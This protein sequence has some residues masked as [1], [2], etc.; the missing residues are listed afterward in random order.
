M[1]HRLRNRV[2]H[3]EPIWHLQDLELRHREILETIGWISPAVLAI[4]RMLDRFSSVYT[5]GPQRYTEEL[6]SVA[7][8]WRAK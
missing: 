1:I 6:D 4:T 7:Q 5:M 8:S 2:F 3:H